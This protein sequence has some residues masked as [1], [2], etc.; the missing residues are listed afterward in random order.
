M[1]ETGVNAVVFRGAML[2]GE[3]SLSGQSAPLSFFAPNVEVF[4]SENPHESI[5]QLKTLIKEC[6]KHKL[7]VYLEVL[8]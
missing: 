4:V 8:L 5:H 2:S 7:E 6:H 3:D 1:A